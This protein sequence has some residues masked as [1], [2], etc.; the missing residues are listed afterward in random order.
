MTSQS[1][2]FPPTPPPPPRPVQK[3]LLEAILF[4]LIGLT[5]VGVFWEVNLVHVGWAIAIVVWIVGPPAL[6]LIQTRHTRR[7]G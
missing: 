1:P 3:I 5:I 7:G 4:G 6:E 2:L